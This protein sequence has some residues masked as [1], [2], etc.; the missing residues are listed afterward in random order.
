M[1]QK[2]DLWQRLVEGFSGVIQLF[3][4]LTVQIGIPSYGLAIIL[5]TIVIKMA[6][7][8][9]SLKQ[10]RSIREMQAIQPKLD[11]IQRKYR[12]RKEKMNEAM[13]KLYREHNINP[14]AGCLPILFQ[15][16]FLIALYQALLRFQYVNLDH[17]GFLWVKNLSVPDPWLLPIL[18]GVATAWQQ[19]VSTLSMKDKNQKMMLIFMPLF[20]VWI[21]RS[22]P[23]G[24]ALYWVVFSIMGAIQQIFINRQGQAVAI[25]SVEGGVQKGDR[26][27]K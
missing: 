10:M 23:A 9:L 12:N 21:A 17:A 14:L 1:E 24:L 8:P 19:K 22:I 4:N 5:L 3:Y 2:L 11:E 6:L 13:M 25:P 26:K 27:K 16:P 18:A 15:M 20:M 7:Y